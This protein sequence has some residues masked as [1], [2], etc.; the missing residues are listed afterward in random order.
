[1]SKPEHEKTREILAFTNTRLEQT[2]VSY[3]QRPDNGWEF[4]S[5]NLRTSEH[6]A[7]DRNQNQL[8]G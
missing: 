6:E 7:V 1:M 5:E 3:R 2:E 4:L 8:G